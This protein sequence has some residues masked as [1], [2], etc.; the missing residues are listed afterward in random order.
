[1]GAATG[2]AQGPEASADVV[3]RAVE[4]AMQGVSADIA[5]SVLLFVTSAFQPTS[6]LLRAASRAANCTQVMGCVAPG[7]FTEQ[8]SAL[9]V[10]AAAALVLTGSLAL[11]H[12]ADIAVD[13]RLVLAAAD[14]LA[15]DWQDNEAC[16]VGGI[17]ASGMPVWRNA[18]MAEDGYAEAGVYGAQGQVGVARGLMLRGEF[19]PVTAAQGH[20]VVFHGGKPALATLRQ[21]CGEA[22]A[23]NRIVACVAEDESAARQGHFSYLPV[24]GAQEESRSVT[25][26]Q[27]LAAGQ[28]LCWTVRDEAEMAR[29]SETMMRDLKAAMPVADF[30]LFFCCLGRSPML[31]V[32]SER[33]L[34]LLR[35][36]FPGL[37]L[38][39]FHGMGEVAPLSGVSRVLQHSAVLGL[40]KEGQV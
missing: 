30:G 32:G 25:L 33:D 8:N 13:Y 2:F 20:D 35:Q 4:L 9:H 22:T 37:P 16:R 40:F 7:I 38:I 23:L 15:A 11:Q 24:L 29:E 18:R 12:Q 3:R 26:A 5:N 36:V 34:Q 39:G 6:A 19:R 21:A 10:P 14:V 17:A 27:P 1:M 31:D 28:W